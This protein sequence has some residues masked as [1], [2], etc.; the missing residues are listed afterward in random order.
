MIDH[1][2][3]EYAGGTTAAEIGQRYGL[4]KSILRLVREAGRYGIRGSAP[5]RRLSWSQCMRAGPPQKEIAQ[6][7]GR[8]Q[9]AVWQSAAVGRA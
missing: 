4:A 5:L 6:R 9:S 2:V 8:S 3:A 7:L 1:L